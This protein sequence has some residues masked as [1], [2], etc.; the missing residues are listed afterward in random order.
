MGFLNTLAFIISLLPQI[1]TLV[2]QVEEMIPA[3]G[4]GKAKLEF[5]LTTLEGVLSASH[6]ADVK[7]DAIKPTLVKIIGGMV[8]VLNS[9]GVFNK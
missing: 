8:S 3:G 2:K 1:L 9:T 5:V 6:D 7:F 4:A